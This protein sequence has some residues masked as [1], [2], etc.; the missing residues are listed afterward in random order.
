[1][2]SAADVTKGFTV[3]VGL[4]QGSAPFLFAIVMDRLTDEA[5]QE[6]PWTILFAD[7]IV[8]CSETKQAASRGQSGEVEICA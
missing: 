1:M 2:R 4:H 7:D 3:K 5:R 6:A 8:I